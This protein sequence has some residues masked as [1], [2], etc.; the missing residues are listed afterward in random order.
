MGRWNEKRQGGIHGQHALERGRGHAHLL[1]AGTT[2]A[3]DSP[4]SWSFR[5][6]VVETSRLEVF[7]KCADM[8]EEEGRGG[9]R[10]R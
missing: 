6:P 10:I 9:V 1:S 4:F 2:Y 5:D 7:S 8:V 3:A